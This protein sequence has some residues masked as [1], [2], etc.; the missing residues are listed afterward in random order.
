MIPKYSLYISLFVHSKYFLG[1][2]STRYQAL[3]R[4]SKRDS[5]CTP[6]GVSD[7]KDVSMAI[8]NAMSSE[9]RNTRVLHLLGEGEGLPEEEILKLKLY[10]RKT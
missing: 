2:I 3:G 8:P 4:S 9:S 6:A 7:K 5:S 1:Y 10:L